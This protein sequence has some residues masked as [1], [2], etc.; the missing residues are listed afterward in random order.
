MI[1]LS[2][3]PDKVFTALSRSASY[4]TVMLLTS[5]V[6]CFSSEDRN[7]SRLPQ[8]RTENFQRVEAHLV[9][10]LPPRALLQSL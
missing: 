1:V 8:N 2:I 10:D 9:P 3:G 7:S 6:V 4:V 5:C